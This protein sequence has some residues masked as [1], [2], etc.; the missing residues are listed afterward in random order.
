[1]TTTPGRTSAEPM[2]SMSEQM[3]EQL[4]GWRGMVESSIPVIVFVVANIL[5]K[6]VF[7]L[8]P[9]AG[10]RWAIG[11]SAGCALIIAGLRLLQKKSIRHAMNGLFGIG[12]G[13]AM[14]WRSGKASDVFL[15]G[16]IYGYGYAAVL[17]GS[18]LFRRPLVGW[19]WSMLVNKGRSDW[20]AH[21]KLMTTFQRLTLLWGVVWLI[22]VSIQYAFYL[23]DMTTA[24]GIA[25]L[26]LGYPPYAL[27]LVV[28]VWWVRRVTKDD[29]LPGQVATS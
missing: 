4:G 29:P 26:L 8:A 18:T 27:L 19:I 1:M 25:R 20:R 9:R 28:T 13:A 14:A 7:D 11:I 6:S 12:I 15:P 10:L 2:P 23:A 16:I 17:L 22:K 24:L 3:A 21:P 5:T